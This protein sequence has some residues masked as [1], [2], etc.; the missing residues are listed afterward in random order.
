M[1]CPRRLLGAGPQEPVQAV[2]AAGIC[3][4]LTLCSAQVQIGKMKIGQPRHNFPDLPCRYE[5]EWWDDDEGEWDWDE[6]WDE[7]W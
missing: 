5:D 7:G 4:A 6:G 1:C 2:E 3:M